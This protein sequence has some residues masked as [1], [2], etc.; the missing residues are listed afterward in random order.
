[1]LLLR[2]GQ[3]LVLH[4]ENVKIEGA[5]VGEKWVVISQR[6]RAQQTLVT[7]ALP[8]GGAMPTELGQGGKV[9]FDEPAYTLSGGEQ[10]TGE[11]VFVQTYVCGGGG[12][13]V[14]EGWFLTWVR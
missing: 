1:M 12:R 7:H 10:W 14:R 4:D 3:V 11:G 6:S 8:P 13:F 9:V 5:S 2:F